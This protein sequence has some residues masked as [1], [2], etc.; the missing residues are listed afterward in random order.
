LSAEE[1]NAGFSRPRKTQRSDIFPMVRQ[2]TDISLK[3]ERVDLV[4]LGKV[5]LGGEVLEVFKNIQPTD[6][7]APQRNNVIDVIAFW[8]LLSKLAKN[9]Q[10][11]PSRCGYAISS[12]P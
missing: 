5:L 11:T 3:G 10:V 2:H 12:L 6:N 7:I 9:L 4:G 8:A 1:E